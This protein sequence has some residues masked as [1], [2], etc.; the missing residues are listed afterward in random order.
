MAVDPAA[1]TVLARG[2]IGEA[3]VTLLA[4][5]ALEF[6]QTSGFPVRAIYWRQG[7]NY[8]LPDQWHLKVTPPPAARAR[9][10]AVIQVSKRGVAKPALRAVPGGVETAGWRVWLPEGEQRVSIRRSSPS[11]S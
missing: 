2:E 10:V 4:P 3:R 9:F 7:M 8:E 11:D 1:R 6:A 5:P